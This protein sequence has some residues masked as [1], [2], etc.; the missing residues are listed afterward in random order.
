MSFSTTSNLHPPQFQQTPNDLKVTH[1]VVQKNKEG[2]LAGAKHIYKASILIGHHKFQVRIFSKTEA[3]DPKALHNLIANKFKTEVDWI[4]KVKRLC[5]NPT[6]ANLD[7]WT[8]GSIINRSAKNMHHNLLIKKMK[9]LGYPPNEEGVCFG[10]AHMGMQAIL[11][12]DLHTFDE[13]IKFLLS[14]DKQEIGPKIDAANQKRLELIHQAKSA[15]ISESNVENYI[16]DKLTPEERLLIDIHPF[17]EGIELYQSLRKYQHLFEIKVNPEREQSANISST[18][19]NSKKI[20]LE[21]GLVQ[22]KNFSG[23]YNKQELVIYL[24]SL[25]NAYKTI[26]PLGQPPLALILASSN[27][28]VTIGY[29]ENKWALIEVNNLPTHYFL[30]E[31]A[32]ADKILLALSKNEFAS[33][34]T[35]VY[36]TKTNSEVLSSVL[37]ACQEKTGWQSIH[38]VTKEKFQQADSYGIT[39]LFTAARE[40]HRDIVK[41][42]LHD[43]NF[44]FKHDTQEKEKALFIAARRKQD[45]II[46]EFLD[47]ATNTSQVCKDRYIAI[48]KAV[49]GPNVEIL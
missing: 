19:A 4:E 17:C 40:G 39:W 26:K 41:R 8:D 48:I 38:S 47:Y 24:H 30:S 3:Q 13:R 20:D 37:R 33:F 14:I 16:N 28:T 35:S 9:P 34:S 15:K 46:R 11:S 7:F 42:I 2:A 12:H 10:V 1:V 32:L 23:V 31:E 49:Y 29:I 18:C 45:E 5:P 27:H 25:A 22:L 6:Q 44:A 36:A 21:G 43:P